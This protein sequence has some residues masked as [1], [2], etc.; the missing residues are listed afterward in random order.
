MPSDVRHLL[1][2]LE[3]PRL[4][5][6]EFHARRATRR[7]ARRSVSVAIAG[8]ARRSGRTTLTANLAD[9]LTRRGL[10]VVAFAL[11][12]DGTLPPLPRVTV[13]PYGAQPEQVVSDVCLLDLPAEPD[14]AALS[15][16][17]EVLVVVQPGDDTRPLEALL[18]KLRP[19][20]R[21]PP[22]RYLVNQF[23]ARLPAHR[24]GLQLLRARLGA[25]LLEPQVHFEPHGGGLFAKGSQAAADV[26]AVARLF[27]PEGTDA[28]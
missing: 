1:R 25:R 24:A 10:R 13:V 21:R 27:F 23:D 11:D 12:P 28:Q 16:A 3:V 15:E 14:P 8:V 7:L 5:Y 18:G 20:W 26:V 4:R 9:V 22:A 19:A 2:L 6:R 17:D